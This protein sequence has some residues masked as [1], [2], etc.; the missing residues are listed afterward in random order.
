MRLAKMEKEKAIVGDALGDGRTAY[1]FEAIN[2]IVP[3]MKEH[4]SDERVVRRLLGAVKEGPASP[5]C[6]MHNAASS[7]TL[8]V[9]NKKS[10]DRALRT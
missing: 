10:I 8:L 9:L 1:S 7:V 5:V 2:A 6:I 3:M 4:L